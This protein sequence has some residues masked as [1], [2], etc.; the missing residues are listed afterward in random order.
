METLNGPI[1]S[2]SFEQLRSVLNQ[3]IDACFACLDEPSFTKRLQDARK[4]L[5]SDSMQVL[6]VGEFSRGK[7]T[8]INALL[9][10]PVL[11]ARVNPTTAA[12][13]LIEGLP[14]RKLVFIY[15]NGEQENVSLPTEKINKF[16]DQYIT[17]KNIGVNRIKQV[18]LS[19]PGCLEKLK[20]TIVDTP[21]VNDLDEVREEITFSYLSQADA[22][23]VILDSQQPL[24]ASERRFLRDRVLGS[25]IHKMLFVINRIDE[26]DDSPE[27][28]NV[29]RIKDYVRKLIKENIPIDDPQVFA[30]SSKEALR[31]RFKNESPNLWERNFSQFEDKLFQFV[32]YNATRGRIPV[33][34]ERLEGI[35]RDGI[36]SLRER[37][38]LFNSSRAELQQ[39]LVNLA[40]EEERL[41]IKLRSLSG[42]IKRKVMDLSRE[43]EQTTADSFNQIKKTF[44]KKAASCENDN[45][46]EQLKSEL[47]AAVRDAFYDVQAV[48]GRFKDNL[49]KELQERFTDFKYIDDTNLPVPAQV[50]FPDTNIKNIKL[51]YAGYVPSDNTSS[52]LLVG[53]ALTF[54]GASLFGPVGFI[55]GLFGSLF[56]ADMMDLENISRDLERQ[57]RQMISNLKKQCDDVIHR[58]QQSSKEIAKREIK[59]LENAIMDQIESRIDTIRAAI[60]EQKRHLSDR[61]EEIEAKKEELEQKT[62][63]LEGILMELEE[64]KEAVELVR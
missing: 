59:P 55:A 1:D 23:I 57:R 48:I 36:L 56:L 31:A 17:T 38:Q 46:L 42:F 53:G 50:S 2:P 37:R 3:K 26:V 13:T 34:L 8:F 15:Q 30:V 6:V 54:L 18:K 62:A 28:N 60:K 35:V 4:R 44:H 49:T 7:S 9:G 5:N 11:P 12:L 39:Q 61:T 14:E 41:N 16:L 25:D 51:S 43:I 32:N 22:C 20:C 33:H 10:E 21:G 40:E 29:S 63:L 27:G 64:M 24:S 45:D 19:W 47:N 52:K 58:A